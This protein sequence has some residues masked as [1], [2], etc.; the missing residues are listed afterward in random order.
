M[1]EDAE[2]AQYDALSSYLLM[3]IQSIA[4]S[5]S[6]V[7]YREELKNDILSR[8]DDFYSPYKT[9]ERSIDEDIDGLIMREKI[10]TDFG[11]GE[12]LFMHPKYSQ[13]SVP[14]RHVAPLPDDVLDR[15]YGDP[16]PGLF[17]KN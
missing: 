8:K 17:G 5:G 7:V 2:R 13:T 9:G 6:G 3:E 16:T 12:A 15:P 4:L 1:R 10:I 11:D 14:V